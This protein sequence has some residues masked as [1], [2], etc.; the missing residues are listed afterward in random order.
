MHNKYI[1]MPFDTILKIGRVIKL[2]KT[3]FNEKYN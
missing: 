3:F 1:T 2:I